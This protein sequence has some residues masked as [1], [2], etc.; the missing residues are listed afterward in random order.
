MSMTPATRWRPRAVF[1]LLCLLLCLPAAAQQEDTSLARAIELFK[2]AEY[3][4]SIALL[5]QILSENRLAKK[6]ERS[7]ARKHLGL[8]Y[9]LLGEGEKAVQAFKG[10]AAEDPDFDLDDL[11]LE[12][13][14]IPDAVRYFGQAVVELR[15]EEIRA[16]AAQM[17]QVSRGT[18]FLR[19]TALPGWG[20]RYQGY[21]WRGYVILGAVVSSI[22]YAVVAERAFR[23]A[24]D[25]YGHAPAATSREEFDRLYN[26]YTRKADQADLA[27]GIVGAAWAVNVL[28]AIFQRPAIP[29]AP[30]SLELKERPGS[31][32]LQ[33]AFVKRF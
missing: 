14:S 16:R 17:S 5:N 12:G 25:E 22:S 23:K 31:A 19:S 15:Q 9:T 21:R 8:G 28:D 6:G 30:T 27:L 20:Q 11:A 33:V 3:E 24:H 13:T 1:I 10:L 18:A 26:D 4:Q 32:G 7:L 29:R 2:A